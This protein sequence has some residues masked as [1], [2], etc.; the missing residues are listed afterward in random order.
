MCLTHGSVC[1]IGRSPGLTKEE[2][3]AYDALDREDGLRVRVVAE[4]HKQFGPDTEFE[5]NANIGGQVPVQQT[6]DAHPTPPYLIPRQVNLP[7]LNPAYPELPR[8]TPALPNPTQSNPT[9]PQARRT[10]LTP[11]HLTPPHLTPSY[12]T[13]P[14][15]TP[16]HPTQLRSGLMCNHADGTRRSA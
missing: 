9:Q 3:A 2:R 15:L 10:P 8:S 12:S 13:P 11:P 6:S 7:H 4:I 16:P 5:L 14:H 1:P